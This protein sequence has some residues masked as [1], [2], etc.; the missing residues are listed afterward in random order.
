MRCGALSKTALS[1][2]WGVGLTLRAASWKYCSSLSA[3]M[4]VGGM[5]KSITTKSA[6]KALTLCHRWT[7][8]RRAYVSAQVVGL[9]ISCVDIISTQEDADSTAWK[10]ASQDFR[11]PHPQLSP[12]S[13]AGRDRTRSPVRRPPSAFGG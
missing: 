5:R 8:T 13:V 7:A 3:S 6:A 12:A 11:R 2:E 10:E 1:G 4:P 9:I